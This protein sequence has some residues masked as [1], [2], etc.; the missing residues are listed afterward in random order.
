F[1]MIGTVISACVWPAGYFP[2]YSRVF[3]DNWQEP[4]RNCYSILCKEISDDK[5]IFSITA[6]WFD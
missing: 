5:V 2:N 4:A 6:I 3:K 1:V